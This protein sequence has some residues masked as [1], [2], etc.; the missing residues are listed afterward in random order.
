MQGLTIYRTRMQVIFGLHLD[1]KRSWK[2]RNALNRLV[3]GPSGLLSQLELYLGLSAKRPVKLQR[4][5]HFR[6][7]LKLLDDGKRFYSRSMRV[8]DFGV[9]SRLLE[10]RDELYLNGWN[11]RFLEKPLSGKLADFAEVESFLRYE[12]FAPGNGERLLAVAEALQSLRTPITSLELLEPFERH[13]LRWQQ[14]VRQLPNSYRGP[15]TEPAAPEGSVLHFLQHRLLFEESVIE[16]PEVVQDSSL[17]VVTADTALAAAYHVAEKLGAK[18]EDAL[19]VEG[20]EGEILD[21]VLEAQGYPRQAF[22]RRQA[23]LSSLQL[24]PLLLRLRRYPLDVEALHAFLTLPE[25]FNPLNQSLSELLAQVVCRCPGMGGAQWQAALRQFSQQAVDTAPEAIDELKRWLEG[26]HVAYDQPM[27]LAE[28]IA[29][30]GMVKE[31]YSRKKDEDEQK[32][33]RSLFSGAYEQVSVFLGAVEDLFSQGEKSICSYQIEQL[34]AFAACGIRHLFQREAGSVPDTSHPG[35]VCENS[36]HV[37]WWWAVS[38]AMEQAAPWSAAERLFLKGEG[39]LFPSQEKVLAWQASDWLRPLLAARESCMLVLPPEGDERHPLWLKIASLVPSIPV[40]QIEES[41]SVPGGIN[42]SLIPGHD[43]P[44]KRPFWKIA[45]GIP[46]PDSPL[47]PTS[48][49]MLIAAPASWFLNHVAQVRP[50]E[51]LELNDG[52]RLYGSL[53]HRLIQ[54]LV[55]R[56]RSTSGEMPV[57]NAWFDA[58]FDELIQSE[59]AV[60]MMPGRGAELENLRQRLRFAVS[61]LLPVLR[62]QGSSTMYAEHRLEGSFAGGRMRGRADLLLFSRGGEASVI[63]MKWGGGELRRKSLERGTHV[64][65][66]AYAAMVEQ[67]TGL[68]PVLAYYIMKDSRLFAT[69]EGVFSFGEAVR[70]EGEASSQAIWRR[71]LE[72]FSWRMDQIKEGILA[73]A[74]S[75]EASECAPPPGLEALAAIDVPYNPYRF[76][77]GWES[78]Q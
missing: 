6:K 57:L 13:P 9:A 32:E 59:G 69:K 17:S 75:D 38:P 51:R 66:L 48:L 26:S 68:W 12:N 56:L 62:E 71:V 49:E 22:Q 42:S 5:I 46:L 3:L 55:D 76:L 73:L 70:G 67:K 77:E 63:D 8:D 19:L 24:L 37:I 11:G 39:V 21:E 1:G 74:G 58:V 53:A 27:P 61:R 64:Q 40:L 14:V 30:A 43:L 72:S 44:G 33:F 4:V 10:W 28:L 36:S 20:G 60:L 2:K 47:S 45:K 16:P 50:S 35:A 18:R 23:A 34:L 31:F 54:T 25:A 78:C 15:F 52:V 29:C 7:I 65:L 41:L